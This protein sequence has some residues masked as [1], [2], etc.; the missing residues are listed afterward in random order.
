MC[1]CNILKIAQCVNLITPVNF[2]CKIRGTYLI[3]PKPTQFQPTLFTFFIQNH[4]SPTTPQNDIKRCG[5][6]L[7]I[8]WYVWKVCRILSPCPNAHANV[9]KCIFVVLS[10][11]TRFELGIIG[12]DFQSSTIWAIRIL[13]LFTEFENSKNPGIQP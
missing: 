7:R 9:K 4:I 3:L 10:P 12:N 2:I 6:F 11:G 8:F 5:I 1:G 13:V